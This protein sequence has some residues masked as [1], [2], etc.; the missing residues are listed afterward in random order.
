MAVS[1]SKT[2]KRTKSTSTKDKNLWPAEEKSA[3]LYKRG[4]L[5]GKRFDNVEDLIK[6][7]HS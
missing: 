5:A 2:K 4:K 3:K 7:L 1:I 6:D